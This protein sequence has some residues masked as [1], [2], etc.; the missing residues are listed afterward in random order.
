MG[1]EF[2]VFV[3]LSIILECGMGIIYGV[4]IGYDPLVVYP[5]AIALNFFGIFAAVF[6]M[7]RLFSWKKGFKTWLES[8]LSRGQRLIDRYGCLGIVMGVVV[9]SPI[10]LAI[11]GRLLG[12]RPQKLYPALFVALLIVATVFLCVALGIFKFLL[13]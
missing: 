13:A 8:K 1:I 6:L 11:V 2:L 5:L 9:L 10:Q 12:I 4:A 3:L 7:D